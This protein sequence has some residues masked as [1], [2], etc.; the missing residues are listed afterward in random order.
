MSKSEPTIRME[1]AVIEAFRQMSIESLNPESFAALDVI[2]KELKT[3]RDLI[4]EKY[5]LSDDFDENWCVPAPGPDEC[6]KCGGAVMHGSKCEDC[7]F[8]V[9]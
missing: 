4:A 2:I 7:G 5:T 8:E 6:P 9:H 1:L 3:T